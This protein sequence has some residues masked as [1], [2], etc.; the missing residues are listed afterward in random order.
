[1]LYKYRDFGINTDRIILDAELYFSTFDKFNDPFDCNLEF[2]YDY[3]D[4]DIKKHIDKYG[5]YISFREKKD[6]IYE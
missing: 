2:N 5:D 6:F 4:E 1:M 3:T